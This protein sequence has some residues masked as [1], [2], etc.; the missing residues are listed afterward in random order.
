VSSTQV[1]GFHAPITKV[2]AYITRLTAG[3][4]TLLLFTQRGCPQAGWQVP[5]GTV[6]SGESLLDAL[7]REV[8]EESG[9]VGLKIVSQL[10]SSEQARNRVLRHA[11]HLGAAE[12]LPGSW[13]H[14]VQGVGEDQGM[15][16]EYSWVPLTSLPPLRPRFARWIPALVESVNTQY[17]T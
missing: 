9:L 16:F 15:V 4:A 5:A 8:Q 12:G 14:R 2:E 1:A 17:L 6:E 11:Y 3:Q 7:R 10:G 13:S